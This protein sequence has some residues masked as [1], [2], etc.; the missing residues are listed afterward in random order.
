MNGKP[1]M[2]AH[3]RTARW[4][5][6]CT[7]GGAVGR[8]TRDGAPIIFSNS[9]DPFD[10]RTRVVVV[11]PPKGHRF[12]AT[13]IV[14]PPPSVPFNQMHTRGVN[15]AGFAYTWSAVQELSGA[16]AFGI[17]YYQLGQL[18]LSQAQTVSDAIAIVEQYPRAYHGNFLFADASGELALVEISTNR[19]KIETRITDGVIARANHWISPEMALLGA[20]EIGMSSAHRYQRALELITAQAGRIDALSLAT[21]TSDHQGRET[22]GASICQHGDVGASAAWC[23][24]TVSSEIIEPRKRRLWYCYGWPCGSAPEDGERQMYQDRSWGVYLPFDLDA[25][26]PGEYVTTDGRLTPVAIRY[27]AEWESQAVVTGP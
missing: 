27:L 18:L 19:F 12:V 16:E 1:S 24:G 6:A 25:L 14:S 8:A 7:I 20:D 23:G 21:I 22:L 3:V 17:P 10:T 11:D 2:R 5:D 15:A 13:Q 9:D 4:F 26:E